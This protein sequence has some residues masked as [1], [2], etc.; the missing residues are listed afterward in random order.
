MR[1]NTV[2]KT[3]WIKEWGIFLFVLFMLIC[4]YPYEFYSVYLTFLPEK[5]YYTSFLFTFVALLLVT[6]MSKKTVAQKDLIPIVAIQIFGFTLVYAAHGNIVNIVSTGLNIAL[7]FS[8]VLLI[9]KTVGLLSFIEKYNKWILL[10]AILGA[11][12]WFMVTFMGYGP[13]SIAYDRADER[14]IFN[15]GLTFSKTIQ[16]GFQTIR[17]S[18]FFDEP[19]AMGY[20]GI[21]ALLFNK[22]FVKSKRMEWLLIIFVSLT[23]SMG[24]YL[25]LLVYIIVFN[26]NTKNMGTSIGLLAV[27]AI[28]VLVLYSTK[29]TNNDWFYETTIG[30]VETI[31]DAADAA[32]SALETDNRAEM[33]EL[34]KKEFHDHPIFGSDTKEYILDNIYEPLAR[35]GIIGTLFVL[36]P[37]LYVFF[38]ALKK[39]DYDTVKVMLVL[40]VSFFHR[41]FHDLI[42]YYFMLYCLIVMIKG[43][44]RAGNY[45][46]HF[47]SNM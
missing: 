30:R 19:G 27:V 47:T 43:R 31:I 14:E 29:G 17:Y 6:M 41:P 12:T 18:G 26:V 4:F 34:A 9:E 38:K 39:K 36:F 10:M 46:T 44:W 3:N 16:Y 8:L 23:F 20:W 2:R 42:L 32:G 35:Y 15:Y 11:I 37:F 21:F 22:L 7:S 40:I 24:F 33:T 1:N 45:R 5:S 13:I 28:G 25:Q